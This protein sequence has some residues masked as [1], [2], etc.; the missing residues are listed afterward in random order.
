MKNGTRMTRIERMLDDEKLGDTGIDLSFR[1]DELEVYSRE[2]DDSFI[3][4]GFR[5]PRREWFC[6][7]AEVD[8]GDADGAVRTFIDDTQLH[9]TT[10]VDTLPATGISETS[11]GIVRASNSQNR[12]EVLIDDFALSTSPLTDCP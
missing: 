5:I 11:F 12:T 4:S 3:A 8:L 1:N 10:G 6:F 2:T 7:R 9:D